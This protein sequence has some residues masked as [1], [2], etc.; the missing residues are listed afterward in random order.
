MNTGTKTA[1]NNE[2]ALKN[3]EIDWNYTDK[4]S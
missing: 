1:E 2:I 3:N 4:G